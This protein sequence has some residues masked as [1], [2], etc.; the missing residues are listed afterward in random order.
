MVEK[1]TFKASTMVPLECICTIERRL[2]KIDGVRNAAIDSLTNEIIVTYGTPQTSCDEIRKVLE[3]CGFALFESTESE[4]HESNSHGAQSKQARLKFSLLVSRDT[5][6]DVGF[7][8]FD[9]PLC[10]Y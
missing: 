2:L 5:T 9:L 4:E 3:E 7:G 10:G 8:V 6:S 1:A